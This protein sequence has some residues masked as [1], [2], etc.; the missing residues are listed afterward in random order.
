MTEQVG[1]V[2]GGEGENRPGDEGREPPRA[3][4]Q[5]FTRQQI[6]AQP[7]QRKAQQDDEV[8]SGQQAPGD[9]HGQGNDPVEGVKRVKQQAD[10]GGVKELGREEGMGVIVEQGNAH[11]PKVPVILPAI[12]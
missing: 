4:P 2:K 10:A 7:T 9:L 1:D 5:N 12:E 8:I 11:P 3:G 6:G